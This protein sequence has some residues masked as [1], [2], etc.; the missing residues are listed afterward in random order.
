MEENPWPIQHL[1]NTRRRQVWIADTSIIYSML[2]AISWSH[3]HVRLRQPTPKERGLYIRDKASKSK[4][5][6]SRHIHPFLKMALGYTGYRLSAK[7]LLNL[8]W[9]SLFR[10]RGCTI[11]PLLNRLAGKSLRKLACYQQV[12][13]R[14]IKYRVGFNNMRLVVEYIRNQYI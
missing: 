13:Y 4:K 1:Q 10:C 8:K 11:F 5:A 9:S 7:S 14:R 12:N 3:L 2:N 6:I